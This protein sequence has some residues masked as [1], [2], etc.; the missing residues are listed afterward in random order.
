MKVSPIT[1][2]KKQAGVF[3]LKVQGLFGPH[4]YKGKD[5]IIEFTRKAGCVQYDPVDVCGKN[6]ELVYLSRIPDFSRKKL[7]EA[8]YE[9]RQLI[10]I[11][12][13]N[14]SIAPV[15]DWPM[16][17]YFRRYFNDRGPHKEKID[18]ISGELLN[19][20]KENGP[21]CSSDIENR[22]KV[23][24][25][26]AP[27]SL[28]R[29]ALDTLYYR[30]DLI[31]HERKNTRKYYDLT[32]RHLGENL[33]SEAAKDR[34]PE[35]VLKW[36]TLRRIK[37]VGLLWNRS[38][39]AFLGM[40]GFKASE[41]N[42]AFEELLEEKKV[43]EIKVDGLDRSM[44]CWSGY[45]DTLNELLNKNEVSKRTERTEFIAPLDNMF[46]DRRLINEIFDFE[47]K[48]EIYTPKAKRKYGYY[49]LPILH[50]KKFIGRIE[51]KKDKKKNKLFMENIWF[52]K[53]SYETKG[54]MNSIDKRL[55]RH[56][57]FYF[58]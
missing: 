14:M 48:W 2:D 40:P 19:Y 21:V 13:K 51:I 43:L 44:Y 24:W 27:S 38:S 30:G 15:D 56:T 4:I 26:W 57:V 47:Y 42:K 39:D 53:K 5:G 46:W 28:A 8:M 11:F 32:E 17:D 16:L 35:N 41:R 10:D 55:D 45:E 22:E 20:I 25:F 36:Q 34:N 37:S 49:V 54:A 52:E 3:M 18:E 9:D 1:I 33:I 12:D 50:G 23:D 58:G 7:H 31:I 6:H 29:A